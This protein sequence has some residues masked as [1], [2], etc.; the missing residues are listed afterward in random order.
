M[1][2]FS[3]IKLTRA[4]DGIGLSGICTSQITF[5]VPQ[6]VFTEL[7][8]TRAA[9]VI[10]SVHD[11]ETDTNIVSPTFY[12]NSR[13]CK[14][15]V[16]TFTCLDRMAFADSV[17]FATEDFAE[18]I[19]YVQASEII[20][21]CAQK[22]KLDEN[23]SEVH[24]GAWTFN[25]P[26][27]NIIGKTVSQ[28]LTEVSE[29]IGG[30]FYISNDNGL[31]FNAY[32]TW[33]PSFISVN[34]NTAVDVHLPCNITGY[35]LLDSSGNRYMYGDDSGMIATAS[36]PYAVQEI[37][38]AVGQYITATDRYTAA[39]C[40][41]CLLDRLPEL[42]SKISFGGGHSVIAH[43]IDITISGEG[44]YGSISAPEYS[45]G[46]IAAYMGR[47]TR[48]LEQAVKV[49]DIIGN[50]ML[51]TRYQGIQFVPQEE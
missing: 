12:V 22:L 18:N 38:D 8:D 37:A 25:I 4:C 40:D 36:A 15:G 32:G 20:G 21:L 19:E 49:G 47:I 14:N 13:T 43:N 41:M 7:A 33:V 39:T 45:E 31:C 24:G 3:E 26:V 50:N 51:I 30:Y 9:P 34:D 5:S 2:Q 11:S 16:I 46:E 27:E 1:G 35:E 23:R 17:S 42:G 6:T 29:V 28:L 10:F 48:R 44:I